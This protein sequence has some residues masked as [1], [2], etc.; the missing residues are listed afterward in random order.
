[1]MNKE[2]VFCRFTKEV[3]RSHH[4]IND[5]RSK[6]LSTWDFLVNVK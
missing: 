3:R 2:N 6:I 4:L 5:L 1:M